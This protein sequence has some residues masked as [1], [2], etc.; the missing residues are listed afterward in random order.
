MA[1]DTTQQL[2]WALESTAESDPIN[3][4]NALYWKFGARTHDM[5][6]FHPSEF[7]TWQ[8][9]YT[10]QY[11][12]PSDAVHVRNMNYG[13]FAYYPTNGVFPYL[14]MGDSATAAGVHTITN[15][16]SGTLPTITIRSE[17]TGGTTDKFFSTVGT[18]VQSVNGYINR[19][20]DFQVLSETIT[21]QGINTLM[22]NNCSLNEVHTTGTK[23]PTSDYTM[24]GTERSGRYK[25]SDGHA[26]YPTVCTWDGDSVI[27]DLAILNYQIVNNL[28]VKHIENQTD[29]E[30]IDEGNIQFLIN[31]SFW[32]GNTTTDGIMIDYMNG[33]QK[34][35]IFTIY[36][37]L[38]NG[39]YRTYT[40]TNVSLLECRPIY[41]MDE[42]PKLYQAHGFAENLSIA[43]KD[44][45][46]DTFYG[47]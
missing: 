30:Y 11:R 13:G 38:T 7:H 21:Y 2:G 27:N 16:N 36:N 18:K 46:S 8:P 10:G 33:D 37:D 22:N 44:G 43:C 6:D 26:S 32:R 17:T 15:I 12:R 47:D 4:V 14:C 1:L 28:Q 39:Y 42:E 31:F 45:V 3:A 9:I 20:S 29:P 34:N 24:T 23:F 40:W 5:R 41:A 35:F 19:L 25:S